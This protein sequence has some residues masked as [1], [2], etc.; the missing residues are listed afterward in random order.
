MPG[1]GIPTP[2]NSFDTTQII[3]DIIGVVA[4]VWM[5]YFYWQMIKAY[6]PRKDHNEQD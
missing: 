5:A 1:S 6:F 4:L 3:A 2:F